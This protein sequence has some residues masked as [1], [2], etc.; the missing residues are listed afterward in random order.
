MLT[1]RGAIL[2][3]RRPFVAFQDGTLPTS[4]TDGAFASVTCYEALED[5]PDF[6]G[7]QHYVL[8]SQNEPPWRCTCDSA[9]THS[10]FSNDAKSA[11]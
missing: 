9:P 5:I 2:E 10:G 1:L 7:D 11:S 4:F 3:D 6:E 8:L